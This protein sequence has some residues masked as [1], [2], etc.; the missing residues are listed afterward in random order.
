MPAVAILTA[1]GNPLFIKWV[2][3]LFAMLQ[4]LDLSKSDETN[5]FIC[6]LISPRKARSGSPAKSVCHALNT[7]VLQPE[8]F[9]FALSIS[10]NVD[11]PVPHGELMDKVIG[12][13]RFFSKTE[14]FD[15]FDC[16]FNLS[17]KNG[18]SSGTL[19]LDALKFMYPPFF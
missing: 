6:S 10:I 3:A 19:I 17:I 15:M 4:A 8:F 1:L 5:L 14:R 9:I 13:D 11:L 16:K 18:L 12:E 7:T 2:P